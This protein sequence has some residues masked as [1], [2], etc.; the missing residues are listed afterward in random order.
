[1][2]QVSIIIPTYN[3]AHYLPDALNSVLAQTFND[4]EAIIVDDGSTDETR[5]VSQQFLEDSRI[6]YVY[7]ENQGLSA[8][9]NTGIRHA[10]GEYLSF[11][12]ADDALEPEFLQR[13]LEVLTTDGS[14]AG[15][16]TYTF[17]IDQAGNVLPRI[18]NQSIPA[19]EFRRRI[20][21]GGFFPV[22]AALVRADVIREVDLF[23]PQ[24][25]SLEDW[26][27]WL[28]VSKRYPMEY[29]P[30]PLVRYR[31]YP[32]SMS[33]NAERMHTNRIRVLTKHFGPP[34][35]EP[36]NWSAEKRRA[37]GFAYRSGALGYIQQNKS[38]EG[39]RLMERAVSVWPSLLERLDTFY[40]LACGD[41]VKGYRGDAKRLD[42]EENGARMLRWLDRFFHKADSDVNSR[43]SAAYGNAYLALAMLSDQARRW[44]IAMGYLF[45]ALKKKPSMI[46]AI[47]VIR[48]LAKLLL[49]T[50]LAQ[51]K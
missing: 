40:E 2:V 9:R 10:H 7:Q 6:H 21:Q 33:T 49:F 38:E 15:V 32:G 27:L 29:V 35:N 13:C 28:R 4:W 16:Y 47:Q 1:M 42:I 31:V 51:I 25:T 45:R 48:R 14:L 8:A 18:G 12:D 41:Q 44:N 3:H 26:D 46:F 39:W 22:H 43:R 24:L 34:E 11:L 23:D 17:F 50:S 20:L 37:Y 5:S 19:N 36:N 30:E